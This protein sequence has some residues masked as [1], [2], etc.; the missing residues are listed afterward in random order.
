M[1]GVCPD[2]HRSSPPR[3][4]TGA[5]FSVGARPCSAAAAGD[6]GSPAKGLG[7]CGGPDSTR[8]P[9]RRNQ[10]QDR[11]SQARA[12]QSEE[13]D[14]ECGVSAEPD[15]ACVVHTD[16]RR[17]LRSRLAATQESRCRD[18]T[19][20]GRGYSPSKIVK[21]QALHQPRGSERPHRHSPMSTDSL[22]PHSVSMSSP[23]PASAARMKRAQTQW[24][25][26]QNTGERFPC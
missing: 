18:R 16:E 14:H 5:A 9:R 23:T 20:R 8:L 3:S 2:C 15:F 11:R 10:Q 19:T 26:R 4:V 12:R 21:L 24:Y 25:H 22:G 1:R 13:D 6:V 17:F 7:G